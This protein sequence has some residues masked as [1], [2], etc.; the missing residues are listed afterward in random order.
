MSPSAII[1]TTHLIAD[2]RLFRLRKLLNL[3]PL[4]HFCPSHQFEMIVP[5][6]RHF[7]LLLHFLAQL[8]LLVL[9]QHLQ[10]VLQ[11]EIVEPVPGEP[12][13]QLQLVLQQTQIF[14]GVRGQE[15]VARPL[16]RVHRRT[17]QTDLVLLPIGL[18]RV[19]GHTLFQVAEPLR[20]EIILLEVD[21]AKL[22]SVVLFAVLE[23]GKRWIK[24]GRQHTREKGITFW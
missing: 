13:L 10:R 3:C 11:R 8:G 6:V 4:A 17:D 22:V 16:Q 9:Q 12:L 15:L 7:E 21:V 18:I 2:G 24:P 23:E 1:T 14:V 20:D 5:L 19:D